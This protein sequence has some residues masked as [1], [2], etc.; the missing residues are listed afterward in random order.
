MGEPVKIVISA[1]IDP[2]SGY[3]AGHRDPSPTSD[4]VKNS[5]T[6]RRRRHSDSPHPKLRIAKSR[7]APDADWMNELL[8]WL[9]QGNVG[10]EQV[11]NELAERVPEYRPQ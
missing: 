7:V 5:R 3:W 10:T 8:V 6:A 11:R 2:L 1:R 4:P 9:Q